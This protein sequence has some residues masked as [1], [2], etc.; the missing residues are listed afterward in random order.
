MVI[1]ELCGKELKTPQA[2]RGH[3]YLAHG[4][5]SNN[6]KPV[7]PV[8]ADQTR[9]EIGNKLQQLEEPTQPDT[10]YFTEQLEQHAHQLTE[11]SEQLKNLSQQ[12]KLASTKT[13][14]RNL[15]RQVNELSEQV[16][17]LVMWL[18]PDG[19]ALAICKTLHERPAFLVDLDNLLKRV[20]ENQ[21][22]INWVTKKY[23]L[24]KRR[25]KV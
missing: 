25:A 20:N 4:I 5:T 12:V 9:A 1:C 8:S 7:N 11:L 19:L 24:V 6:K 16:R 10:E 13:E 2:L 15:T 3:K 22:V 14:H 21:G 17:R 18:T 23:N